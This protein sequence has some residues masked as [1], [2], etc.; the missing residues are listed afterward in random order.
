M[1]DAIAALPAG[2][3]HVHAPSKGNVTFCPLCHWR[4]AKR[5]EQHVRGRN[6]EQGD[7]TQ[8]VYI[9]AHKFCLEEKSEFGEFLSLLWTAEPVVFPLHVPYSLGIMGI[10]C[11]TRDYLSFISQRANILC[12]LWLPN[13]ATLKA[14]LEGKR[15]ESCLHQTSSCSYLLELISLEALHLLGLCQGTSQQAFWRQSSQHRT[16]A[17]RGKESMVVFIATITSWSCFSFDLFLK[18]LNSL[19][20]FF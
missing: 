2:Y 7:C 10:F 11:Q 1:A 9:K 13:N 20:I 3:T 16:I 6:S 8:R 18:F 12:E 15:K 14:P 5:Q 4:T 17:V 19:G